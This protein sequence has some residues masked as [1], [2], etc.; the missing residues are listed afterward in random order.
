[1]LELEAMNNMITQESAAAYDDAV[2]KAEHRREWWATYRAALTGLLA[3]SHPNCSPTE[4][5][6]RAAHELAMG[7][8]DIAHGKIEP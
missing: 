4:M 6:A 3:W 7:S 8:A 1:M 2:A 5:N